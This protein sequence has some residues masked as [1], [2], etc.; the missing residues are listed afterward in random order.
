VWQASNFKAGDESFTWVPLDTHPN[1][2]SGVYIIQVDATLID[3]SRWNKTRDL[4]I[5]D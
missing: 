5:I 2:S 4:T 3:G 1:L